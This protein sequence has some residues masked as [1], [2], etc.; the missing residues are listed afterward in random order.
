[1][2]IFHPLPYKIEH[3]HLLSTHTRMPDNMACQTLWRRGKD[4]WQVEVP[5]EQE[6]VVP[7]RIIGN[8]WAAA[9]RGASSAA[10]A[11]FLVFFEDFF[12]VPLISSSSCSFIILTGK[13]PISQSFHSCRPWCS[14]GCRP[15]VSWQVRTK[16]VTCVKP[17]VTAHIKQDARRTVG[18]Y[19]EAARR[20]Q[21]GNPFSW[22]NPC[23][24]DDLWQGAMPFLFIHFRDWT[25]KRAPPVTVMPYGN[26]QHKSKHGNQ[27]HLFHDHAS[28]CA[29][30]IMIESPWHKSLVYVTS[31]HCTWHPKFPI[32]RPELWTH[33]EIHC[34]R[35]THAASSSCGDERP[36]CDERWVNYFALKPVAFARGSLGR[37][38]CPG[39]D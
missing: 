36:I 19:F 25:L 9:C 21:R 23:F 7:I 38:V 17:S 3:C 4:R 1:M 22:H 13:S 39:I 16:N 2:W 6:A 27:E 37:P 11:A 28:L 30:T 34:G 10:A 32:L 20:A 5:V 24:F 33:G 29:S 31:C 14:L 26:N 12:V 18:P 35:A 15:S 8:A